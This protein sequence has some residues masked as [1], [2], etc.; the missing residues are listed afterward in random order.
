VIAP[1]GTIDIKRTN[2]LGPKRNKSGAREAG[3][4]EKYNGTIGL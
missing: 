3:E 2:R 4:G 1:N